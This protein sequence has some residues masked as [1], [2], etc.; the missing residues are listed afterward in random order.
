[1][2]KHLKIMFLVSLMPEDNPSARWAKLVSHPHLSNEKIKSWA[3]GR[4]R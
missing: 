3:S 4:T 1:M 2:N